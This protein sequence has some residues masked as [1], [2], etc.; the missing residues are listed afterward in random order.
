SIDPPTT[1]LEQQLVT[2]EI[3]ETRVRRLV[4]VL[5]DPRSRQ[6]F[7]RIVDDHTCR[8]ILYRVVDIKVIRMPVFQKRR[9]RELLHRGKLWSDPQS[10]DNV[11]HLLRTGRVDLPRTIARFVPFPN[12]LLPSTPDLV[13]LIMI[14]FVQHKS[15]LLFKIVSRHG[16]V[17]LVLNKSELPE[18]ATHRIVRDQQRTRCRNLKVFCED[19]MK[20]GTVSESGAIAIDLHRI[21]TTDGFVLIVV[22]TC[23][24][25]RM[26]VTNDR[27]C[28]CLTQ[29]CHAIAQG[30]IIPRR[31]A[32]ENR[33]HRTRI[34][35]YEEI[36]R[37]GMWHPDDFL[38]ARKLR[39]QPVPRITD[40]RNHC[41][42]Q[43]EPD[44]LSRPHRHIPP[45]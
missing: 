25:S 5:K 40:C 2:K 8:H 18:W 1:A 31:A 4:L 12:E 32:D 22:I 13:Q 15:D 21:A 38:R 16:D 23:V 19:I 24:V 28:A 6:Y 7:I 26:I 11:V 34:V 33:I 37:C 14:S 29:L 35:R 45:V 20:P 44:C 9:D 27:I 41:L 10:L 17:M 3:S 36:R 39:I 42:T 43:S 30:I